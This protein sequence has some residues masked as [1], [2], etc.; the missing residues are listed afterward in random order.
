MICCEFDTFINIS[1][2]FNTST[3]GRFEKAYYIIK[4]AYPM[5]IILM[6]VSI[7]LS[8]WMLAQQH[9]FANMYLRYD[10]PNGRYYCIDQEISPSKLANGTF[11]A[12][13][14]GFNELADGG[15]IGIQTDYSSIEKGLFIFSIWN[16][17]DAEKGDANSYFLDFGGEGVGKSC[18][19]SIPLV[20]SHVYRLRIGKLEVEND[21][22]YWGA[23]INEKTENKSYFLGKIKTKN[24]TSLSN[25]ISNFVEYYGDETSC[26]NVPYSSVTF[27]SVKVN[28][29]DY[30][31]A[32]D[33]VFNP[34]NYSFDKCVKGSCQLNNNESLV[35]F[36]GN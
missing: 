14:F 13:T 10:I 32:C 33:K 17:V 23:W 34:T 19:I 11:W 21:G 6:S 24:E 8:T 20:E 18:R 36:G 3:N 5:K 4:N 25:R 26:D 22:T 9:Q 2:V 16:A 7:F 28:C 30:A 29:N 31:G 27:S 35:G 15:Y 12:L 1:D